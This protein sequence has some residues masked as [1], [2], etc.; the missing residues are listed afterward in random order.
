MS[1]THNLF[2]K[3]KLDEAKA[4]LSKVGQLGAVKTAIV[5]IDDAINRLFTD[6]TY[7]GP[8]VVVKIPINLHTDEELLNELRARMNRM[9]GAPFA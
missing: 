6:D 9:G 7:Y 1:K 4:T 2:V 8:P 5:E 3:E